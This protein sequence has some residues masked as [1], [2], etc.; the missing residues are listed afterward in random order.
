MTPPSASSSTKS[1][2]NSSDL[3]LRIYESALAQPQ[4]ANNTKAAP[5]LE[6]GY[7]VE[8]GEAER[9][10]V[11][12][13]VKAVAGGGEGGGEQDDVGDEG[14]ELDSTWTSDCLGRNQE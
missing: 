5:F 4:D 8:T 14:C 12:G 10:A 3:P 1:T 2:F 11:D 7:T 6:L 9:I 13:A